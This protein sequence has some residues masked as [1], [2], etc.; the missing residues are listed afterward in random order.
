MQ[1]S[2]D[3][4][5][6]ARDLVSQA[7]IEQLEVAYSG[8]DPDVY[9]AARRSGVTHHEVMEAHAL[10]ADLPSYCYLR[11]HME[12]DAA[13]V[14]AGAVGTF[15]DQEAL[16]AGV[17]QQELDEVRATYRRVVADNWA[18]L[19]EGE[20]MA[21]VPRGTAKGPTPPLVRDYVLAR[22]V[23]VPHELAMQFSA[24]LASRSP[25]PSVGDVELWARCVLA[26][27]AI[28]QVARPNSGLGTRELTV[29][30]AVLFLLTTTDRLYDFDQRELIWLAKR[31][32]SR[33]I[34]LHAYTDLRRR[35]GRRRALS[36]AT[37]RK[38]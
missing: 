31:A 25:H 8:L 2:N 11:G 22:R 5:S 29:L 16:A 23:G 26:G 10:G 15:A 36:R 4:P 37:L 6:G 21:L 17:R 3:E 19:A 12:H 34:D 33:E 24:K 32:G 7:E 35:I 30:H 27:L 1:Q 14:E 13:V 20:A 28:D 9:G 18:R 38:F